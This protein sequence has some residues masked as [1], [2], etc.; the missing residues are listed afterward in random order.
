MNKWVECLHSNS[1]YHPTAVAFIYHSNRLGSRGFDDHFLDKFIGYKMGYL[2]SERI[3]IVDLNTPITQ[4][5]INRI[6]DSLFF[7]LWA[8]VHRWGEIRDMVE[9]IRQ[10]VVAKVIL[11]GSLIMTDPELT[12]SLIDFDYGLRGLDPY[13]HLDDLLNYLLLGEG[14]LRHIWE[15]V[16]RDRETSQLII[17]N[18]PSHHMGGYTTGFEQTKKHNPHQWEKEV[19]EGEKRHL[20]I[21]ERISLPAV[22]RTIKP[23]EVKRW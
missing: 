22:P 2:S 5:A 4:D 10:L 19:A 7:V 20:E 17:N 6:Q 13:H 23:M 14:K 11:L 15:V 9:I 16:L 12:A 18:S 1:K 3:A 8:D 21:S